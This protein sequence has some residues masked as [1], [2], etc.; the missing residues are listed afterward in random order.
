MFRSIVSAH[1]PEYI[2]SKT[3][4]DKTRILNAIIDE[5]RSQKDPRTGETAKFIKFKKAG[6]GWLEICDDQAREKV[7]HAIRE[8]MASN[9]TVCCSSKKQSKGAIKAQVTKIKTETHTTISSPASSS[10]ST[11]R[12]NKEPNPVTS[13]QRDD[14]VLTEADL[15]LLHSRFLPTTLGSTS[16]SS[17][18]LVENLFIGV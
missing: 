15:A 18:T 7:G 5:V 9:A 2:Q 12:Q 1:I 10:T 3:K 11:L 8:A 16:R 6:E 14:D 13:S 4:I 17:F